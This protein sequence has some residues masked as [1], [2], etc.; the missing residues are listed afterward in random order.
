MRN[1]EDK[2]CDPTSRQT[3]DFLTHIAILRVREKGVGYAERGR[4]KQERR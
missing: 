3:P 4:D 1:K 2:D